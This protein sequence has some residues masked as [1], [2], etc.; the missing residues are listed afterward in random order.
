[1]VVGAN[2]PR[3]ATLAGRVADTLNVHSW[4]DDIPGLADAARLAAS[5]AGRQPIE[6]TVES[7]LD[8]QWLDPAS[9][10]RQRLAEHDITRVM[11]RWTPAQG[12]DAIE[13]AAKYL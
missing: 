10:V 13:R 4:E 7:E 2:G 1:M 9:P 8:D 5:Q 11:L 3:M 6:V 12:L